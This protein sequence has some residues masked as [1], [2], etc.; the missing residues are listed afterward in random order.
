MGARARGDIHERVQ[1]CPMTRDLKTLHGGRIEPLLG[2]D[3][4]ATKR[5]QQAQNK[6]SADFRKLWATNKHTV[7]QCYLQLLHIL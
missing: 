4:G 2:A 3:T 6:E 5:G 7:T 1:F